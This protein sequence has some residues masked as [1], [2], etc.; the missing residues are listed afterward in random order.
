MSK[1][2]YIVHGVYGVEA[3]FEDRKSARAEAT[4]LDCKVKVCAWE[5]QDTV[6]DTINEKVSQ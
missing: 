1:Q 6:S 2:A 4:E 3:I 5:D